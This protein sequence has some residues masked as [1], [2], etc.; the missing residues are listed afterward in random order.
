MTLAGGT[1]QLGPLDP[2]KGTTLDLAGEARKPT[3]WLNGPEPWA[4]ASGGLRPPGRSRFEPSCLAAGRPGS[5]NVQ[6]SGML[7]SVGTG[8]PRGARVQCGREGGQGLRAWSGLGEGMG[9]DLSE[10]W[11][12]RLPDPGWSPSGGSDGWVRSESKARG[13]RTPLLGG[14]WSAGTRSPAPTSAVR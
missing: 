11:Q 7:P 3:G 10:R 2:C 14:R 12:H 13:S 8:R 9:G 1:P 6:A 5:G 4:G